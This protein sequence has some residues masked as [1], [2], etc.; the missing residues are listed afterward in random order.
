M[1]INNKEGEHDSSIIETISKT[2]KYIE[3]NKKVLSIVLGIIVAIVGGYLGYLKFIVEPSNKDAAA[4]M[5]VAEKYFE[6]D[7]LDLAINGDGNFPGFKQIIEDYGMT[8]SANLARYYL[9]IAYLKKGEYENA[10]E[11]L[12]K[13]KARDELTKPIALGAI[14]DAYMEL[15]ETNEALMSYLKAVEA[16]DNNFTTPLFLMKVGRSYEALGKYKEALV[17]YMRIK[18]EYQKANEANE[19][20][21]YI[22]RAKGLI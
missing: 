2:E 12:K 4:Q 5:Y 20:D 15:G 10:I 8:K 21:K 9:G 18:K 3:E 19:I 16:S 13:Y 1:A 7:S 17:A 14:G 22:A 6:Q 11:N